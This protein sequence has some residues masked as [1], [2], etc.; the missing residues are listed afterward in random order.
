MKFPRTSPRA[1]ILVAS[2]ISVIG[3]CVTFWNSP[4]SAQVKRKTAKLTAPDEITSLLRD[5]QK[6][7]VRVRVDNKKDRDAAAKMGII[8]AED[9]SFILIAAE[10]LPPT[11]SENFSKVETSINLPGSSFDPLKTPPA[12]TV[13]AE[14]APVGKGYYIVQFGVTATDELLDSLRE[15]GSTIIQYIP[16]QA[17][18]V[19]G[20]GDAIGKAAEHSRV[21]WVGKYLPEYKPSKNLRAQLNAVN[22]GQPPKK[23]ISEL[24]ETGG[25]TAIFDV[26][27][28]SNVDVEMAAASIALATSGKIRNVISLPNNFFNIVRI[29]A[30]IDLIEEASKVEEVFSIESWGR[31][32]KEDEVAAQIVAGNYVGNVVA[33]PGYDPLTQFGVNGQGITVSVVDDGVGI[34]G[35]GGFYITSGNAV[36]GPL[37]GATAGAQGHGHLQASIIAGDSPYSVLDPN[38]YNYGVG[39]AP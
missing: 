32:T 18:V 14:A 3:F 22:L 5:P 16:H 4:Q 1:L 9:D 10:S 8:V 33:P 36:D 20:D 21:R 17:F 7:L 39:I 26:A 37:R 27:V 6:N 35:D 34:P 29:E 13:S 11:L 31:P 2:V 30:S 38:G 12:G 19:Y 15:S 24:E 28:F 23:G 25:S